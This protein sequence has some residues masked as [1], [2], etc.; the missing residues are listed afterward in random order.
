MVRSRRAE[1]GIRCDG[2]HLGGRAGSPERALLASRPVGPPSSL[3]CA[4]TPRC[5]RPQLE[6]MRSAGPY[7]QLCSAPRSHTQARLDSAT[8]KRAATRFE[9]RSRQIASARTR[10]PATPAIATWTGRGPAGVVGSHGSKPAGSSA[11]TPIT[12]A[13]W[14]TTNTDHQTSATRERSITKRTSCEPRP[15]CPNSRLTILRTPAHRSYLP[16]WRCRSAA[17][18]PGPRAPRPESLASKNR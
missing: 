10:P 13:S 3:S 16:D 12:A 15:I 11:S 18:G 4:M 2:E 14:A 1:R 8:A 17:I 6:S 9:R 7:Q 5:W